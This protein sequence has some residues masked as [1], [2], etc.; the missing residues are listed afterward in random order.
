[1]STFIHLLFLNA[2]LSP[3]PLSLSLSASNFFSHFRCHYILSFSLLP[4]LLGLRFLYFKYKLFTL[5]RS[6]SFFILHFT[7]SRYDFHS[8]TRARARLKT[9]ILLFLHSQFV[10]VSVLQCQFEFSRFIILILFIY[11]FNFTCLCAFFCCF[12]E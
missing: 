7:L 2:A 5:V 12:A 9:C 4:S 6:F 3:F 8:F 1:M 10:S 11:L